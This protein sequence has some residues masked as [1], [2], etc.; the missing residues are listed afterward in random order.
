MWVVFMISYF[1]H[2]DTVFPTT[3]PSG[4]PTGKPSRSPT[5]GHPTFSPTSDPT[6]SPTPEWGAWGDCIPC[7]NVSS[8]PSLSH[9]GYNVCGCRESNR[10][11]DM[12]I[13]NHDCED[14][15]YEIRVEG[16]DIDDLPFE[17][18]CAPTKRPTN[19]P[20][21]G[22]TV[23]PTDVPTMA[24]TSLSPTL[25]PTD[26]PTTSDP[27]AAPTLSPTVNATGEAIITLS[28]VFHGWPPS[29]NVFESLYPLASLIEIVLLDQ[30][31]IKLWN[32]TNTEPYIMNVTYEFFLLSWSIEKEVVDLV[33]GVMFANMLATEILDYWNDDYVSLTVQDYIIRSSA[34]ISDTIMAPWTIGLLSFG[35]FIFC[36]AGIVMIAA[37]YREKKKNEFKTQQM[38]LTGGVR[39]RRSTIG[40]L[41][42]SPREEWGS[43]LISIERFGTPQSLSG[44]VYNQRETQRTSAAVEILE[45][46]NPVA[47]DIEEGDLKCDNHRKST[48]DFT[49]V[50]LKSSEDFRRSTHHHDSLGSLSP[51][52]SF[53]GRPRK[54]TFVRDESRALRKS[55]FQ[56]MKHKSNSSKASIVVPPSFDQDG[57]VSV[58][59]STRLAGY[60]SSH[61]LSNLETSSMVSSEPENDDVHHKVRN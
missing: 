42:S 54:S 20:S 60:A 7:T 61:R 10:T 13:A 33:N 24:P 8:G 51:Y 21:V 56:L 3:S 11:C 59:V 38:I 16:C 17:I 45:K 52:A 40:L 34:L 28:I 25:S 5:T 53:S 49:T 58:N 27:T 46:N 22:P 30:M 18:S 44:F 48:K 9:L 4:V 31:D 35:I 1:V 15:G 55:V 43:G 23:S 26:N 14:T 29:R 32:Y 47:V 39:S 41:N 36:N 57:D 37:L 12:G 19:Y 50:K 2:A 6:I